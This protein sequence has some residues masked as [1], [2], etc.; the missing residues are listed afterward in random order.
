MEIINIFLQILIFFIL[1][2]LPSYYLVNSK[3]KI[4]EVNIIE[5]LG[6]NFLFLLNVILLF[7][8]FNFNK[9]IL[10]IIL[11]IVSIISLIFFLLKSK[12]TITKEYVLLTFLFFLTFFISIDIANNFEFS[13]D[14]KKYYLPRAFVF[15]QSFFVDDLLKH[16]ERPFYSTYIWS[17]F[18]KNSPVK[19]EYFGRMIYGYIYILSIFYLLNI[20]YLNLLTKI[21][22]CF[23]VIF[24][25]YKSDFFDGRPDILMFS[26]FLFLSRELFKI[27]HESKITFMGLIILSLILNLILWTKSEGTVYILITFFSILFFLKENKDFKIYLGILIIVMLLAKTIFYN[28]WG[29]SLNP[30]LSHFSYDFFDL[31]SIKFLIVRTFKIFVWYFVYFFTNPIII[32][33][34][35]VI[36]YL[37]LF[38]K[39]QIKNF[40]Y[41]YCFFI[42]KFLAIY[43][44]S[45]I[46]VYELSLSFH[47]KYTLD[48]VIFHSSGLLL[49]ISISCLEKFKKYL[50]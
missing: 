7:S 21:V 17:F 43:S 47:L 40:S 16:T 38:D 12:T 20:K 11:L 22:L 26:F 42:L 28:Y 29:L 45:I 10:F 41:I 48:R 4:R 5:F 35:F 13:W 36:I 19:Y 32:L 1:S 49:I 8:F 14:T 9:E 3:K 34:F 2:F 39:K 6:V 33:T 24:L 44:A 23:V 31:F 15:F 27:F 37:Y 50:P 30:N 25:T 18:W 46:S